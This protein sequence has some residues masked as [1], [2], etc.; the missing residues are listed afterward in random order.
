[1]SIFP[2]S[3]HEECLKNMRQHCARI[4]E[5]ARLKQRE[6]DE[7]RAKLSFA[8]EQLSTAK[9]EGKSSY[10]KEKYL[11]KRRIKP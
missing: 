3:W 7:C 1:M 6:F 10:D 8:E 9:K 2:I 11:I 5:V 4:G